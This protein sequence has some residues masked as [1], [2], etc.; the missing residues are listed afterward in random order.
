MSDTVPVESIWACKDKDYL[1]GLTV[2]VLEVN[3]AYVRVQWAHSGKR[4]HI[5][6]DSFLTR[7]D[8]V[9]S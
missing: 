9:A 2:R 7:F 6:L 8:R 5:R 4:R 1:N 3:N